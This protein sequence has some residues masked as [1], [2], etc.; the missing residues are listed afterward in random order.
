M[1]RKV[2]CMAKL[3]AHSRYNKVSFTV[4]DGNTCEMKITQ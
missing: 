1:D 4:T 3:Q 2:T